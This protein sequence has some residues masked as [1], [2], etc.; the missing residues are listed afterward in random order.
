MGHDGIS[1]TRVLHAQAGAEL[2]QPADDD[3]ASR[4]LAAHDKRAME[5]E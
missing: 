2:K 5:G 3:I 1:L 4:L